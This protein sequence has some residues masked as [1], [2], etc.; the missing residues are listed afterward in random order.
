MLPGHGEAVERREVCRLA[1]RFD[2]ELC[3]DAPDEFRCMDFGG[4]HSSQ[5]K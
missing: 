2:I 3:S 4:K 1:P 5:K